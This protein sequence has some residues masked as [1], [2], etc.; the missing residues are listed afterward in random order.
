MAGGEPRLGTTATY[1]RR[2][3]QRSAILCQP[4]TAMLHDRNHGKYQA[5]SAASLKTWSKFGPVEE[6]LWNPLLFFLVA[7]IMTIFI[8]SIALEFGT[9]PVEL[10][11]RFFFS[12]AGTFVLAFMLILA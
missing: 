6:P 1:M 2:V 9:Q 5:F 8:N 3:N 7:E 10:L 12:L 4:Q 11:G